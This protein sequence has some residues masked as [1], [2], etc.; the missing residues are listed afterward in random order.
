MVRNGA[1]VSEGAV[2]LR[3]TVTD[4]G[5][6]AVAARRE[7]SGRRQQQQQQKP[8]ALA[9]R[10]HRARGWGSGCA[11]TGDDVWIWFGSVNETHLGGDAQH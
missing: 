1:Q 7:H 5:F 10:A 9:A 4:A 6:G 11:G 8:T 3:G 2:H